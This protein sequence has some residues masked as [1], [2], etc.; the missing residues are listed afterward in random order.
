LRLFC[1]RRSGPSSQIGATQRN[2]EQTKLREKAKRPA[3]SGSFF[4]Q[5]V[6]AE[7]GAVIY[8]SKLHATLKRN[9]QVMPGVQWL[10]LLCKHVPDRH[11]HLVRYYGRY[12]SRTRGSEHERPDM[13]GLGPEAE[14]QAR[15]AAKIAW[16]KMIR[17]VYEVDPLTCP[18]CGAQMRVI[19]LIE[20]PATAAQ[21]V[22]RRS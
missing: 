5:K 13:D 1:F 22:C 20:D 7:R 21:Q 8:R 9:F 12:S 18:E 16:A 11:E 3:Q 19:L 4:F 6:L 14:S 10:E 15:R 2:I 17:K